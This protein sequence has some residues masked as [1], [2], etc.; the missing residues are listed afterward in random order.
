MRRTAVEC[1]AASTNWK[2]RLKESGFDDEQA[3]AVLEVTGAGEERREGAD[4]VA[5]L[6]QEVTALKLRATATEDRFD[7]FRDEIV[8]RIEASEERVK[9]DIATLGTELRG[10]I[11][12]LGTE[13]RGDIATLG[14]ELRSENAK[15]RTELLAE[16]EKLRTELLGE[17]EKLRTELL[18]ENA[19]LRTEVR[20]E[21]ENLRT[22]VRGEIENLRTEVRGE[23]AKL[24]AVMEARFKLIV[25]LLGAGLTLYTG[26]T[27][28]LM[29][30]LFRSVA[31]T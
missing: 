22:E 5:E 21:I 19:N 26:T 9:G 20:G 28:S 8:A 13:L 16:N 3:Q 29:V 18:G 2:L 30:L 7:H 27:I 24:G 1:E 4:D 6:S 11:A 10:D 23:I 12:T 14:T 31:A 25:W 17:N 15:L